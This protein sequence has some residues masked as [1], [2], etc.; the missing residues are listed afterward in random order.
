MF[1]DKCVHTDT[2][3]NLTCWEITNTDV[4]NIIHNICMLH[5]IWGFILIYLKSIIKV[6]NYFLNRR[7]IALNNSMLVSAHLNNFIIIILI[8]R[9]DNEDVQILYFF[10]FRSYKKSYTLVRP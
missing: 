4:V 6:I 5:A 1:T 2:D 9:C 7:T 10:F 8:V 3:V